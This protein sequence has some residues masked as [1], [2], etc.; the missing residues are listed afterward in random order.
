MSEEVHRNAENAF[1]TYFRKRWMRKWMRENKY[2]IVL[3]PTSDSDPIYVFVD[4]NSI[5]RPNTHKREIILGTTLGDANFKMW[6]ENTVIKDLKKLYPDN[7]FVQALTPVV[8]TRTPIGSVQVNYSL[9]INMLPDPKNEYERDQ[10]R[11]MRESFGQLKKLYPIGFNQS[12][13]V[14]DLFYIY[15]L[16]SNNGKLGRKSLHSIFEDYHGNIVKSF[17]ESIAAQDKLLT[18]SDRAYRVFI[19]SVLTD[20]VLAPFSTPWK[21]GSDLIKYKNPKTGNVDLL[22]LKETKKQITYNDD[23]GYDPDYEDIEQE[24][25]QQEAED[26]EDFG[27]DDFD[28]GYSNNINY[29]LTNY[30]PT[31]GNMLE[32]ANHNYFNYPG[33]IQYLSA[34]RVSSRLCNIITED[35]KDGEKYITDIESSQYEEYI[36]RVIKYFVDNHDG[37]I[38]MV[39]QIVDGKPTSVPNYSEVD[40]MLEYYKNEEENCK[41]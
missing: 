35:A 32:G 1:D 4:N 22:K 5:P 19:K 9:N 10:L 34:N 40:R 33:P 15:S 25:M 37:K 31:S 21:G 12:M 18:E 11:E 7:K 41:L 16:I 26:F 8:N 17:N 30:E 36:P 23:E 24:L 14:Q 13:N 38:P 6:F 2:R 39:T 29:S 3:N 20:E 27:D 28:G